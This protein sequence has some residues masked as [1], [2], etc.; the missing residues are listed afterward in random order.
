M[1]RDGWTGVSL[2]ASREIG[3]RLRSK[4]YRLSTL[5]LLVVI[6]GFAVVMKLIGGG[7]GADATVGVT[8]PTSALAAPLQAAGQTVGETVE[9]RTLPDEAAGRAQVSHGDLDAL[10]V[11]DG[12]RV[13]VVV[14]KDLDENLRTALNVLAGQLALNQQIT[15]LGGDPA[16]VN[17]AVS[18]AGVE[19]SP[20]EQPYPYNSQQLVLGIVAG[21]LIYMSLLLNGQSVAQ[22]VVEEKTSRV[23]ELL[24]ATVR[25]WQLMAGKVLGIGAVGLIQ[26][27]LIGVVGIVAG[28]ATDVLT[29]SVSAAAGTVVWLIVWYLLGFL[30]YSIVFA[31]LG[32][33]VSRQEDVGGAVTPA[34]FFVIAGYVVGISVLPSDP[35][36]GLVALLS[37]IPVFAPTLMPMRLAMGGVAPWEA[38]LSVALVVALIPVLVWL[39]A[40][41]YRNAVLRTGAK[42]GFREALR[43]A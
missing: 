39:S 5:A 26:M 31:G 40:R 28:L 35:G 38:I 17:A 30:M 25:P 43:A 18:G 22:G 11:G 41:I 6:V 3:I 19:V 33:L 2:V 9:V 12:S 21:I 1:N 7:S 36:S 10:L 34:L 16:Q 13:Q 37:V 14:K 8:G 29:I 23:V 24:L 27:V 4:A 15:A 32:A 42:V 20:M